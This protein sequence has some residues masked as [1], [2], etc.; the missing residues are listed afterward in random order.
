MTL[1]SAFGRA[2]VRMDSHRSARSTQAT[3]NADRI[4]VR[5]SHRLGGSVQVGRR[6]SSHRTTAVER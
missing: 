2:F 5:D 4:D 3:Q 6:R 1:T